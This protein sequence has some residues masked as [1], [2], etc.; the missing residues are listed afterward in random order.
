[1]RLHRH[2]PKTATGLQSSVQVRWQKSFVNRRE[3]AI[4]GQGSSAFTDRLMGQRQWLWVRLS[5]SWK[6]GG[7]SVPQENRCGITFTA[8]MQDMPC[9]FSER[10]ACPVR[11]TVSAVERQDR[12][13]NTS[14]QSVMRQH[15]GQRLDL[16][17]F[18]IRKSRWC[19]C[20]Q[21]FPIWKKTQALRRV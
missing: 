17:K 9:I 13:G 8:R 6:A 18:L 19:I 15:R 20:A 4:S 21:I 12:F 10:K 3:S 7:R 2:F 1:M 14:K 5:A 11:L 16:E